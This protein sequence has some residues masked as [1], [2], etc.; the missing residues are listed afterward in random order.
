MDT[1]DLGVNMRCEHS[2]VMLPDGF[3]FNQANLQDFVDCPR[4]F[5][6]RYVQ[7]QQWPAV[8]AEPLSEHEAFVRRGAQFHCLVERHQLG[9]PVAEMASG[10]SDSVLCTWWD[11]YLGFEMLHTLS[12]ERFPELRLS[13]ELFG[14]RVMAALD[15]VVVEP[16]SRVTIFDWKT[17]GR[18]PRREWLAFRLQTVLYLYLVAVVGPGMLGDWLKPDMLSMVY[19]FPVEPGLPVV[20]RYSQQQQQE[21]GVRLAGLVQAVLG[22]SGK[23]VW[24]LTSETRL[25]EYCQFRSRCGR[26]VA[27]G[28]FGEFGGLDEV[29]G[30]AGVLSFEEVD[31]VGF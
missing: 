6:L 9:L 20:F 25:C 1:N 7:G 24:S 5:Q 13:A 31:E 16:G 28:V 3:T 14:G 19:W 26:G 15:L 4:R 8:M 17:Y 29:V 22:G 11:A 12:G 10:L 18:V 23:D 2:M 21:D 27:A 30:A